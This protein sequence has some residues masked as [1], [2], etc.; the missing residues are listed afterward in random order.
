MGWDIDDLGNERQGYND[1]TDV[2]CPLIAYL[3]VDQLS[4]DGACH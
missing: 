2:E 3:I 4:D 1:A